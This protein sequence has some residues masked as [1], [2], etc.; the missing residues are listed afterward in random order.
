MNTVRAVTL[1]LAASLCAIAPGISQ[2]SYG[3]DSVVDANPSA[4]YIEP[5]IGVSPKD[6]RKLIAGSMVF[7]VGGL[8]AETFRSDDGGYSWR[9]TTL[10]LASGS[11]LGDVQA[12]FSADGK[13][14]MTVLGSEI[15]A[16]GMTLN[17]LYVFGT[18][19]AGQTFQRLAFV[20][21]PDKHSY[22][23]EQL[24]IDETNGQYRGRI[25]M[26]ALYSV[27][28]S[29]QVNALGLIWSSDGGRTFHGPVEV[30][31]GW[32][33]N[34]RPVVLPDGNLLFPF[35]HV[36][37]LTDTHEVLAV[38]L[39]RDG[40]RSFGTPHR[41]GDRI[42]YGIDATERRLH[43]GD[44]A[45]DLDSVPQFAAASTPGGT[46]I[47]GVWSDMRTAQSRLLFTRSDDLGAHWTQPQVILTTDHPLDS[48]YQP[49]LA[50]ND[51][52]ALGI[53]WY[54]AAHGSGTVSEMFAVSHDGGRSFSASARIS[55]TSSPIRPP[56]GDGYSAQA[57]PDTK[58][59]FIGFTS[60][61]TRY[62][63][64]GDYTGLATDATGAFHPIWIDARDGAAQ[65]WTATA[66]ATAPEPIPTDLSERKLTDSIA[67]EFGLG[68]WDGK[69]H[70]FT[71][72]VRLHN[73]SRSVLYPPF[74]VTVSLT[75]NPYDDEN[76]NFASKQPPVA[77]L[78]ADNQKTGIGATFVYSSGTIGNLGRLLP[79]AE[80]AS[81]T[82]RVRLPLRNFDP[83]LLTS[84]RGY[85]AP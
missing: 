47:F 77:V 48:Q 84:V 66:F 13:G 82:W 31:R 25:Y 26:S 28:L 35:F 38:S 12:A 44:Y 61:L 69:S 24:T 79:G 29:P 19:D 34:S 59:I 83:A 20:Q 51:A 4:W 65:V 73:T 43:R 80:T 16:A 22:D 64:F 58:G 49:S 72:P 14:Y 81:R 76:P 23:H 53:S 7:G 6:A 75:H 71:V 62:P 74:T 8:T 57:F 17:G 2:P 27:R 11:L 5:A 33:F 78:N 37:T 54:N 52:G 9:S 21:T 18:L 42:I 40:G 50:V 3:P 46:E 32:S 39:S 85:A 60:P 15:D 56:N 67:L 63:S 36:K 30:W 68:T 1:L 41:V 55:S 45:F 70:T 10:P